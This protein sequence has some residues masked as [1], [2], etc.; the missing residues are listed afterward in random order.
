MIRFLSSL[1]ARLLLV[2]CVAFG[3]FPSAAEAAACSGQSRVQRAAHDLMAAGRAGSAALVRQ[4]LNRH[5]DVRRVMTFALGRDIRR[6]RGEARRRY[7][8]Q[9]AAYAA[10]QLAYLA[11]Q[12]RGRAVRVVRCGGGRVV[13]ELLPQGE[14]VVWKLR[15]GRIVDVNFRGM[16]MAQLLRSRFRRM[17]AESHYDVN[18][19]IARLN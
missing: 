12:V 7:F 17:L 15:R 9:A 11:R 3:V 4:V 5:V 13:T 6:L 10:R 19:F 16:W 1:R 2:L 8:R 18:T 14:R